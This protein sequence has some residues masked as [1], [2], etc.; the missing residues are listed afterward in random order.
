[1][2]KIAIACGVVLMVGLFCL[3]VAAGAI[4]FC[5]AVNNQIGDKEDV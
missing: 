2:I 3:S 1:M 5:D 4:I